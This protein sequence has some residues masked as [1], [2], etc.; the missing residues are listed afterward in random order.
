MT[1]KLYPV[2]IP[3]FLKN[4]EHP[5]SE[6]L[7]RPTS[8]MPRNASILLINFNKKLILLTVNKLVFKNLI[9]LVDDMTQHIQIILLRLLLFMG[10]AC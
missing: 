3:G 5:F 7:A 4:F 2:I 1:L 8:C 9:I 6:D 10:D